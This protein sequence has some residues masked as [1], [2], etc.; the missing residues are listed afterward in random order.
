MWVSEMNQWARVVHGEVHEL[1]DEVEKLKRPVQP[2]PARDAV[3][4][5]RSPNSKEA[6]MNSLFEDC[7][8]PPPPPPDPWK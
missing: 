1:R 8:K 6:E 5:P 2:P 3:P 4:T 7:A